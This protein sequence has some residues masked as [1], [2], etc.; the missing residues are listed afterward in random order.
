MVVGSSAP[1]RLVADQGADVRSVRTTFEALGLLADGLITPEAP[2]VLVS[3]SS[4]LDASAASEFVAAAR[5]VN[6]SARLGLLRTGAA[7]DPAAAACF[8]FEVWMDV[9]AA[10][11]RRAIAAPTP[12]ATAATLASPDFPRSKPRPAAPGFTPASFPPPSI[13]PTGS[14]APITS[15]TEPAHAPD[16]AGERA[17]VEAML[18]SGDVLGPALDHLRRSLPGV[19][20]DFVPSLGD[21]VSP[22]RPAPGQHIARV[23]HRERTFAFILGPA[24]AARGLDDGAAWL[25]SWLALRE[26]HATLKHAA[27]TDPLTGAWNRRYFD[28][29][30]GSALAGARV[31]RRDVSILLFDIDNFKN[32]NDRWGHPA[33]DDILRE[34]VRLLNSVIRPSDRVCRIGGD[35]FAVIFDEPQGPRDPRSRHPSS[36]LDVARRF[37]KQIESASFP[38]LGSG[39]PGRLTISGGMATYPWDAADAQALVAHADRLVLES[40]RLGKNAI[41]IGPGSQSL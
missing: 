30:L 27:F 35:E 11:I 1:A 18:T 4:S 12:A 31:K 17:V 37:Q 39:A 8:D 21:D 38:K 14:A 40:K 10:A 7:F 2:A 41:C 33:G 28:R 13:S 9:D 6:P 20:L 19:H 24:S 5:R 3:A 36:I 23:A 34:T 26:Q 32:Y 15:A 22:P 25:G 16:L 29:F